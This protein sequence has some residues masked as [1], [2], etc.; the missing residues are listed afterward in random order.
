MKKKIVMVALVAIGAALAIAG[1]ASASR[2]SPVIGC[3]SIYNYE[4][5]RSTW[6]SKPWN[7]TTAGSLGSTEGIHAVRWTG[8]G[9]RTATG[10]GYL[11]DGL[12]FTYPATI[13]AFR[14]H[15]TWTGRMA[16]TRLHVVAKAQLRAT[17]RGPY[18][19]FINVT[20]Q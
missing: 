20:P 18:N 11:V 9:R 12:G 4:A 7:C 3:I 16:Y 5:G 13:T 17:W 14:I 19:V 8:W 1:P 10:H 6:Q 15:H 2:R